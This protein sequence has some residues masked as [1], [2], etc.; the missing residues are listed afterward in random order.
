MKLPD[1]TKPTSAGP[2]AARWLAA[3][4]LIVLFAMPT[5][6]FAQCAGAVGIEND[7]TDFA[8]I[9]TFSDYYYDELPESIVW[10]LNPRAGDVLNVTVDQVLFGLSCD[11]NGKEVP[12][13]NGNDG[14]EGNGALTPIQYVGNLSGSCNATLN[15]NSA[16]IVT[17][18]LP[19]LELNQT[20]CT[21]IFETALEDA[22]G[23][24]FIK[25]EFIRWEKRRVWVVDS[26]LKEGQ[27]H[28][29]SRRTFYLE[30]DSWGAAASDMYDGRGEL[31]RLQYSYG[32][33]MYDRKASFGGGYGAYD[34]LQNI[35]NL[36]G[37]TIPGRFKN[38]VEQNEKYFTAKGMARGGVR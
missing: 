26:N 20:G 8:G 11:D 6:A 21:I 22:L 16:G 12:C 18:D 35:Y 30:E 28:L 1:L 36:N 34:L 9:A 27:R 23:T 5:Q 38:G 10:S 33:N 37:K 29:Y 19:E 17:F 32:G 7:G 14:Q 2:R 25:P 15:S 31:W 3:G 24:K 13:V 4:L